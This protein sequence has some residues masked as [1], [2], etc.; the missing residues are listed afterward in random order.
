MILFNWVDLG[1]SLDEV[2]FLTGLCVSRPFEESWAYVEWG[3]C[4]QFDLTIF[5]EITLGIE[6]FPLYRRRV[7]YVQL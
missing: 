7:V 1:V 3:E 2:E 4:L 5:M 6:S